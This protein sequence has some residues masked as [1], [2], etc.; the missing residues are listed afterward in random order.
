MSHVSHPLD[1]NWHY[2]AATYDNATAKLYVDGALAAQA[3]STI[4]LTRTRCR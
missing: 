2:V 3:S 1:T 4:H